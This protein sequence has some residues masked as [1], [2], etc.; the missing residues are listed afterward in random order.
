MKYQLILLVLFSLFKLSQV[1]ATENVYAV[2]SVGAGNIDYDDES[3]TKFGYKLGIGY[4]FHRQW[5]MEAGI[6]KFALDSM[7]SRLPDSA[8][9]LN[10]DELQLDGSALFLS[11]LGKA[12]GPGDGHRG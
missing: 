4:Q 2:A 6:Q 3:N 12:A 7:A 5:Y 8:E 10:D 1:N 9:A 11:V